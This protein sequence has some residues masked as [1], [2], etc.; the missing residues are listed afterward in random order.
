[1]LNPMRR[2][3]LMSQTMLETTIKHPFTED[4]ASPDTN[5]FYRTLV[6]EID[7]IVDTAN[8]KKA[9]VSLTY[10]ENKTKLVLSVS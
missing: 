3:S 6:D 2:L 7:E 8:L 1:M 9:S 10:N 4:D 5:A